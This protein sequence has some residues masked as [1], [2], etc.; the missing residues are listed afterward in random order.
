M[1][2]RQFVLG[3]LGTGVLASGALDAVMPLASKARATTGAAAKPPYGAAVRADLLDKDPAYAAALRKH[4]Q[5]VVGEGGLKWIDLRPDR[6]TFNFDQSDRLIAF[7]EENGM[8]M[9]GH[10]LAWYAAMPS[11]AE[12]LQSKSEAEFELTHHIEVVVGRYRGRIPSWDVVN[13][14]I[15]ED[16]YPNDIYR[17]SV[18]YRTLGK[19]Y[20][21]LA[22]RTAARADP[23]AQLVLNDF[24]FEYATAQCR[25]RRAVMLDLLKEL[26]DKDVPIHA[27]G[28]QGH[29]TG[30]REIDKDGFSRFVEDVNALGLNI[31]VTELDVIDDKLPAAVSVRDQIVAARVADF[32]QS[33]FDVVEPDAVLTWGITDKYTWVPIW[34]SREDGQP[35]RPLPLD[36]NYKPKA[37]MDVLQQYTQAGS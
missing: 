7:A 12:D 13:E 32:L 20:I 23:K 9:R 11:W 25:R 17:D 37:F 36:E 19:D 34:F 31:L 22:F 14:P 3:A 18:W 29:L 35:N 6:S 27:F 28:L 2:R 5:Q 26:K 15:S 1:Q 4:C 24:N 8:V 10:T 30:Q 21:E 16:P 33:V